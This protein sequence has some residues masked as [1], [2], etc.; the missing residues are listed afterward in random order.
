MD[1]EVEAILNHYGWIV[2]CWTPFEI[3]STETDEQGVKHIV[4][5]A[6]GD[7]ARLIVEYLKQEF[8]KEKESQVER[9][10]PQ[11]TYE[12]WLVGQILAGSVAIQGKSPDIIAIRA[13]SIAALASEL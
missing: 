11:I 5:D 13:K 4:G 12:Q 9:I 3:S 6:S 10:I 1:K 7:G 2:N 8:N